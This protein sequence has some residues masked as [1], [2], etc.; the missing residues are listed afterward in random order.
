MTGAASSLQLEPGEP[1]PWRWIG[2]S[3]FS[4]VHGFMRKVIYRGRRSAQKKFSASGPSTFIDPK[5]PAENL[6]LPRSWLRGEE[7]QT[8]P[9]GRSF[10]K[11]E[12]ARP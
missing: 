5:A 3:T 1:Q 7:A 8:E 12:S 11:L 4:R 10:G 2:K 9:R 6:S